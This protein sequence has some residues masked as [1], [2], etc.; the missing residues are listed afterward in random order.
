[1]AIYV[2]NK[3]IVAVYIGKK[4]LSAIYVGTKIVWEAAMKLW[5]GAQSWKQSEMWKY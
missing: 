4:A 3:K 1:M 5:K 2:G